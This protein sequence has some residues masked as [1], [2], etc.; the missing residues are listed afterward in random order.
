MKYDK[1]VRFWRP[2]HIGKYTICVEYGTHAPTTVQDDTTIFD[3]REEA[4]LHCDKSYQFVSQIGEVYPERWYEDTDEWDMK[5]E[6]AM[7]YAYYFDHDNTIGICKETYFKSNIHCG[8]V[9]NDMFTRV[10]IAYLRG[11]EYKLP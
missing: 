11:T 8:V 9:R 6:A 10:A 7:K 1:L 4:E 2:E 5:C 3:T